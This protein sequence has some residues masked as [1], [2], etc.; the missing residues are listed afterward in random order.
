M[1][2]PFVEIPV[3]VWM[4]KRLQRQ[5]QFQKIASVLRCNFGSSVLFLEKTIAYLPPAPPR[6]P[7]ASLAHASLSASDNISIQALVSTQ[8]PMSYLAAQA[9]RINC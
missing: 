2:K 5:T 1:G 7:A 6:P 4:V 8:M 3:W 9:C